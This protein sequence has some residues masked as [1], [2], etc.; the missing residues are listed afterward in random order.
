M[1]TTGS[2]HRDRKTTGNVL[3]NEVPTGLVKHF[4]GEDGESKLTT[5]MFVE[6]KRKLQ[7]EVMF[8]EVGT[9]F[10]SL[11]SFYPRQEEITFFEV[12]SLTLLEC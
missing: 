6:F 9:F 12:E 1:T 2:Q 5:D 3:S 8:L 4:F 10:F 7:Q 11:C